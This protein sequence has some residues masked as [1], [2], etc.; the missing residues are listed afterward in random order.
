MLRSEW[1]AVTI[2]NDIGV[3]ENTVTELLTLLEAKNVLIPAV[4]NP[5]R[6]SNDE[7]L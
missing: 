1:Q 7:E 5:G 6:Y 4:A 3:N 2:A